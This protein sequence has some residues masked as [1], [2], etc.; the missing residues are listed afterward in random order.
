[1]A[2]NRPGSGTESIQ[3]G[4][5]VGVPILYK[6]GRFWHFL[7]RNLIAFMGLEGKGGRGG[8]SRRKGE[9][10][11][12][13]MTFL[14]V[15][16]V[17]VDLLYEYCARGGRN[18]MQRDQG[19]GIRDQEPEF[20]GRGSGIRGQQWGACFVRRGGGGRVDKPD[21]RDRDSHPPGLESL[22]GRKIAR[23]SSGRKP[24]GEAGGPERLR[25]GE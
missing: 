10:A 6:R 20:R 1:M 7:R 24:R 13:M 4:G 8:V 12:K 22:L 23:R 5:C 25:L 17:M 18:Y 21:S 14:W 3:S 16:G 9:D 15:P 2:V 19:T 11:A